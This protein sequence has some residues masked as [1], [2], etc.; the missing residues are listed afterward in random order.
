MHR[1]STLRNTAQCNAR[2]Q[3]SSG[4]SSAAHEVLLVVLQVQKIRLLLRGRGLGGVRVG[5]V[6]D[7]QGQE[8]RIVFI[9]T[10][11]SQPETLPPVVGSKDT[12]LHLGFWRNPR[13]FNVAITRAKA[14]LVVLGHPSVL[15]EVSSR[16]KSHTEGFEIDCSKAIKSQTE[17]FQ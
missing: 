13:R 17:A 1:R 2:E 16:F 6:D 10:V 4:I 5:T 11:L 14:L 8:A 12:D 15:I 3:G 7:M 9:S